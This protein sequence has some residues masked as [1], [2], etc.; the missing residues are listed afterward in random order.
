[1][2][3]VNVYLPDDLADAV[4]DTGVP[5]SSVCQAALDQ[6][7]RRLAALRAW[8]AA[9]IDLDA[10]AGPV[11]V[12][13]RARQAIRLAVGA[14]TD[15]GAPEVTTADLLSGILDEGANL[16]LLVLSALE[17]E[18]RRLADALAD[19][20][21]AEAGSGG[22]GAEGAPGRRFAAPAAAALMQSAI[23]ALTLGHN[24]LGCEHLLLGLVAEPDG[25]AGRV[26]REAGAD[27]RSARRAVAAALNGYAHL[28][29]QAAAAAPQ[30]GPGASAGAGGGQA[31][32]QDAELAAVRGLVEPLAARLDDIERRLGAVAGPPAA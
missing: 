15:R 30:A 31:G 26:L 32:G 4:K 28:R 10:A 7:V 14:A 20:R 2:P 13:D 22:S 25:V 5:V 19:A 17:I 27:Q 3:K 8:A 29:A 12:T 24:Y 23:E 18:P 6:A 11:A 1:M 9:D 16:A 21:A